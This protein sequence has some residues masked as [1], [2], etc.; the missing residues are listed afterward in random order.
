MD[1]RSNYIE[2]IELINPSKKP[3]KSEKSYEE[4]LRRIAMPFK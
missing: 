3:M 4:K 2:K 1:N